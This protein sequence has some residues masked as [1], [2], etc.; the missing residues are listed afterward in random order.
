MP[1]VARVGGGAAVATI[2]FSVWLLTGWGSPDVRVAVEDLAFIVLAV[3]VT[4]C[5]MYATW[6]ARGRQ[7]VVWGCVSAG[8]IGYTFGSVIWAYYEVWQVASPFPSIA[9]VAYLVLPIFVCIGL[10]AVPHAAS[11]Y[12][13]G[14]LALD[15]VIVAVAFF[16]IGWWTVVDTLLAADGTGRFLLGIALA[17]PMLDLGVL[18]VAVLVLARA[19]AGQR[20]SLALLVGG[21]T[22]IAVG[23]GIF[24]FTN[25]HDNDSW[26][27]F[28]SIGWALGLLLIA[29]A[30][31]TS[32]RHTSTRA[33][34]DQPITRGAMWLP[35]IPIVLALAAAAVHFAGS[36]GVPPALLISVLLI[37]L[38]LV[39]QFIVVGE[40]SRLLETVAAQAMRD[41][42]TGLA[43]RALL[44]DRL[45]H[46][47][48]LHERDDEAVTV[49]SMDL[50]DFKLV[51]DGL[52]HPAGDA[53]L[54][55]AAERIV[56]CTRTGDTVARMGGDEF[57]VLMEGDEAAARLVAHHVVAAFADPFVVDGYELRL[58][59]SA[60]LAVANSE[61][62]RLTADDL[63]KRAD[64]AMYAAKRGRITGVHIYSDDDVPA[65]MADPVQ[66]R[67]SAADSAHDSAVAFQML[68]QLRHAIDNFE[69]TLVYQPKLDL[70]DASII[71]VEALVRWPHPDRGLLGPDQ[72]LQLVR[73]H[74]LMRPINELVLEQ[75]LGQVAIWRDLGFRVPVAV[76]IFAPS[77]A[78]FGLPDRIQRALRARD[79]PFEIL[80][81]E[82]TE[83]LLLDNRE[84]AATAI[85]Q[86]RAS[87]VRVAI[88]DF[89]SGY[90][91]L[92][93]LRD[94]H[95]DELKLDKGFVT[96]ITADRR[97]GA[98]VRAVIDLARE[99]GLSTVAEGVEN[100]ETASLLREYGCQVG[101]GYYFS[102]PLPPAQLLALLR[103]RRRE[104][105]AAI[106]N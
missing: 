13:H 101:Q 66:L 90:S 27:P 51:N 63:L 2:A 4:G 75:A 86:L 60:G 35:Y 88:D 96:T 67:R 72:F 17:Y 53:L 99:L 30:A 46:A 82:I 1:T 16:Q 94:L 22:L 54:I 18:T 103:T 65:G 6:R 15:G 71:G 97:A 74:G 49:L 81:V 102:E 91:A 33:D 70:V 77:L 98:I 26:V 68:G 84:V 79:L 80:T 93:Y 20:Q 39:R 73:D 44:Q 7:R 48:A 24:V 45:T 64:L 41:P 37:V 59:P 57:V 29:L 62:P 50:D 85:D 23:D 83:D 10:L 38:V 69:L 19:P 11:G 25:T 47:M 87:G 61:G 52:G 34:T 14:R 3:F 58:C 32:R 100:A 95:I 9:D 36:P 56:T 105:D 12:T 92:S 43:N 76:N 106:W 21:M 31:L 104:P 5:C 40:N 42:L 28:S 55:Q 89:G 78:D 8:M